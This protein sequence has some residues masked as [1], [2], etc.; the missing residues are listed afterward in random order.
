MTPA[1]DPVSTCFSPAHQQQKAVSI[2]G[3]DLVLA[4]GLFSHGDPS[5]L[6]SFVLYLLPP[7]T[8]ASRTML[9][10][11][12]TCSWHQPFLEIFGVPPGILPR[13]V[14]NAEVCYQG[15]TLYGQKG[16]W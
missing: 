11:L 12:S 3:A 6:L 16:Y 10:D 9:M 2:P 13:I 7:V 8:N 15:C 4:W 1:Y 14:S 5:P